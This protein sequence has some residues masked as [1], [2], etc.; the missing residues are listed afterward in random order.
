M[1][2]F[3]PAISITPPS[4]NQRCPKVSTNHFTNIEALAAFTGLANAPG[5]EKS[6]SDM[7]DGAEDQ[8]DDEE[9][10]EDDDVEEEDEEH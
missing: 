6:S 2:T 3:P 8:E 9:D 5:T 4:R 10:D 7:R 1:L